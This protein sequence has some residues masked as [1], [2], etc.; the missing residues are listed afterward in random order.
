[1]HMLDTRSTVKYNNSMANKLRSIMTSQG[2]ETLESEWW[3][4]QEN[5]YSSSPINTFHLK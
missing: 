2:F 5:N 1:M 4:F 3:H